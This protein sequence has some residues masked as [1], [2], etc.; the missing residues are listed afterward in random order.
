MYAA[1]IKVKL[2]CACF[3]RIVANIEE[4]RALQHT[5]GNGNAKMYKVEEKVKSAINAEGRGRD[6]RTY[7]F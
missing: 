5:P 1:K 4:E 6:I 7:T 2:A 3:E